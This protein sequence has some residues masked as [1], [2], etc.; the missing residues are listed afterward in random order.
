MP[1]YKYDDDGSQH[2]QFEVIT[3]WEKLVADYAGIS[4]LDVYELPY[5]DY[6]ILRRDAF[7]SEYRKSEKGQEW[8][9]NAWRMTIT[10][11]DVEKVREAFGN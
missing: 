4:L 6:L 10:T 11:M 2:E 7:I 9:D 1:S 3:S 8:L 5:F